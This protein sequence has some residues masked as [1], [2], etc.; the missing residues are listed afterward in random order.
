MPDLT[1]LIVT[2][3][4]GAG[5]SLALR[6]LEDLGYYCVDNLP[7]GLL[8]AFLEQCRNASPAVPRAALAIDSRESVFGIDWERMLTKLDESDVE[9]RILF[10]DCRDDVLQRRYGETRRRHPLA[11]GGDITRSISR[12]RALLQ[13]LRERAHAVVDTSDLKPFDFYTRLEEALSLQPLAHLLLLFMSFGYKRGLPIDAD[14]VL[15]M[16]FLPNPFY[17]PQ[18]RPLSGQDEPVCA[19]LFQDQKARS[20]FD[21]AEQMLRQMLPGF[22]AQGKQRV[23]MAFGCTGGRHRSVWAAEEMARRFSGGEHTVRCFH[24]DLNAEADDIRARFQP[25][26]GKA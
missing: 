7:T 5:K 2:G 18:L 10:L 15:D 3:L 13:A 12:E 11:G 19:Y 23:M 17:E 1:L 26:G 16:R 21:A 20:F 22:A 14:M 8:P 9:Y 25:K 4:S 6:R 24:R